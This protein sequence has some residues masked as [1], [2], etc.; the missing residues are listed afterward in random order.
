MVY[1]RDTCVPNFEWRK[2]HNDYVVRGANPSVGRKKLE[3]A[4]AKPPISH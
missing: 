2:T 1:F 4:R 3:K